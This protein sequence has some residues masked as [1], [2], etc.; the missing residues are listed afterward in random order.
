MIGVC[1]YDEAANIQTLIG[2]LRDSIPTAD[3]LVVDDDSPDGTGGIVSEI[4]AADPKVRL[5]V[6]RGQRGLGSAI[7]RAA[8]EAIEHDYEFFLNLDG[9]LSHQPEDL[10]RLLAV[11]TKNSDVD[12]V[13]GSRYVKG[14]RIEGWPLHRRWMSRLINR[15]AVICLRLPVLDCSGSIRCYRVSCAPRFGCQSPAMPKLRTT[16]RVVDASSAT[17]L[18]DEGSPDHV[19]R[20][21]TGAEQADVPR[22]DSIG[23]FHDSFGNP[24]K[25][26]KEIKVSLWHPSAAIV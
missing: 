25:N 8:T 26:L 1:T 4:A 17:G 9:D 13:V 16:G 22:G 6:R 12:V 21:P 2:G 5:M 18:P 24:E 20:S 14:G 23:Q 7:V 11:A 19:Y 3:I 15:F 10:A